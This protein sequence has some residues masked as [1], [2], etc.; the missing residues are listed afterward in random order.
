M[1]I[2][3]HVKPEKRAE[4]LLLVNAGS[5]LEEDHQQGIAHFTE[6]MAFNGSKNFPKNEIDNYLSSI[7]MNLGSHFNDT[8][9]FFTTDYFFEIPLDKEKNLEKGIQIL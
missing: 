5:I 9:G 7:G 3:K 1:S 8:A 2:T 4:L 6:H